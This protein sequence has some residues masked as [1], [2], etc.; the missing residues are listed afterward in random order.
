MAGVVECRLARGEASAVASLAPHLEAAARDGSGTAHWALASLAEVRGDHHDAAHNFQSA[1]QVG[2]DDP[3]QLPWRSGLA[4]SL[5][6]VGG[7]RDAV[8]LAREHLSR[9]QAEAPAYVVAQALRTLAA[10]DPAADRKLLLLQALDTLE[11]TVAIRLHAQISTD[12]AGV[13]V[14]LHASRSDEV[15]KLLRQAERV[16]AQHHLRPLLSRVRR[17]LTIL[18]QAESAWAP[19]GLEGLTPSELRVADLAGT[20]FTNREIAGR[21][22]V[23]VKAV[24]WHLS[25]VYRKLG[26]NS[27]ADL[28][29]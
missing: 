7:T 16:A 24:E 18:D 14:L 28:P 29:R 19:I 12:L 10:V 8:P 21:L 27:R 11:G 4:L 13:M 22:V 26:I 17:L 15:V 3:D 6:R 20:G 23:T 25:N 9:S 2:P 1:G 5:A